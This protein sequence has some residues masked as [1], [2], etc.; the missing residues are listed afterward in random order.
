M[1]PAPTQQSGSSSTSRPPHGFVGTA[2]INGA[3]APEGTV[4]SVLINGNEVTSSLV[5]SD[6]EFE[7]I[8]VLGY[9]GEEVTFMIGD[10]TAAQSFEVE[11]GELT[12]VTLTATN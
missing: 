5:L 8:Q 12:L 1:Q 11:S 3:P 7:P 4:I 10:L 2:E 9:I 6:G